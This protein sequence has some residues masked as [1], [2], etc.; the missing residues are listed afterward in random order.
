MSPTAKDVDVNNPSSTT[1]VRPASVGAQDENAGKPQPV[2]LEVPVTVNGART[3]EGSDK[4]E[5]FSETTQTVLVFG[6][7]AVIRLAS[8]VAAG[9]LLFLTNEKTKKEVVC[10]VVKSKNY[11]N[12]SG[13]VELEFTEAIPGFWGMRFPGER[14]AAPPSAPVPA[15]VTKPAAPSP[16][17]PK[18]ETPPAN[19]FPA[20]V[21]PRVVPAVPV[22][23]APPSAPAATFTTSALNAEVKPTLNLPRAPELKPV[24]TLPS[25]VSQRIVAP[26][27][28]V[29]NTALPKAPGLTDGF[30]SGLTS[31]ARP[32]ESKPTPPV[33][34]KA[35]PTPV[36][37]PS[38]SDALRRESER[39]QE[40]LASMLFAAEVPLTPVKTAPVPPPANRPP[41]AEL[42]SKVVEM[43]KPQAP[44]STIAP[45]PKASPISLQ[46]SLDDEQVKIPSWLEPLA[47]NA[48][49]QA[50]NESIA[51]EEAAANAHKVIEFEVQ[52]VSA[53]AVTQPEET[54]A[55]TEA[56]LPTPFFDETTPIQ[57]QSAS[58]SKNKV[59]LIGAIA[60]GLLL[61]AAGGTW[62]ARQSSAPAQPVPVA[63]AATT[64]A[65]VVPSAVQPPVRGSDKA[66]PR[67]AAEAPAP[68]RSNINSAPV[69]QSSP[70]TSSHA[71][72]QSLTP[73]AE[74]TKIAPEKV[75]AE[76][77]AYK[78]LAEPQ[79]SSE[80]KKPSI[81]PVHL[82]AP[83]NRSAVAPV[84]GDA[85]AALSLNESQVVPSGDGLGGAF[86]GAN[87]KQPAAPVAPLPIG[88]DVKAARLLSSTSPTYPSLAKS[89]RIEGAVRVDALVDAN[90]RIS[91]MKVVSGPVLL[92]QAAMDAL[93]QWK[94]QPATLDGKPVSMH[95][96][97]TV[98]F[99]LQ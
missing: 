28:T 36:A 81:G 78:K 55:S 14:T 27:S 64:P 37:T 72:S 84:S 39:L 74:V 46:S 24:T 82:S 57:P 75:A 7:G 67:A 35:S 51:K 52:D 8:S 31:T 30:G 32:A 22:A 58:K 33:S 48:A 12:V 63:A 97:V 20:G 49:T 50:Q 59:V 54:L 47:R 5:P 94:Y 21:K 1:P 16:V 73:A 87:L 40:Q 42:S 93:H 95:L 29:P 88:G 77:S 6:N 83:T 92:H 15:A 43:A 69:A 38:S 65:A 91:S 2:P 41:T 86:A 98:Q 99:R 85:D 45:P 4:R 53:P 60:A 17:A 23:P 25:P 19:S 10:Q 18:I 80:V 70:Q 76:L 56:S 9:Q 71:N 11:R 66:A 79:P 62:Y 61:V 89:Q 3:V 44:A 26:V 13:Y 96:T 90:G 34:P 68:N